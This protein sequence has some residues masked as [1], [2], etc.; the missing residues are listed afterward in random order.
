MTIAELRQEFY[1]S[2]L[3][4]YP[5]EEVGSFLTILSE[6]ILNL[7]RIDLVL[8]SN[9]ELSENQQQE[10]K[11][12]VKRLQKFEPIQYITGET[13]F[14]S[15]PF[16]VNK[17]TLIPRPET[18][19]LV[20][21]ILDIS[22]T[23]NPANLDI[24]DIGTG[25][26]CIAISLAKNLTPA[27]VSALDISSEALKIAHRNA[28][29]NKVAITFE[30][31][32]ILK[33]SKLPKLYDIIVSNPPYVREMEKKA[34]HKNVLEYEPAAA[35]FVS[36]VDPL[37]FYK[38]IAR[39][40]KH[41]LKPGGALFFEINEYLSETL[42]VELKNIGFNAIEIRKDLFGKDRMIKCALHE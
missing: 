19:E 40:A 38:A 36:N 16:K 27:A 7:K 12:A 2:L 34:M 8:R 42:S 39:L 15:L 26:G 20:Q 24:L 22:Q 28:I 9:N 5:S 35:L 32:D 25:S 1:A 10:F 33:V 13:E 30:Q 3:G 31:R 18:E 11:N 29:N 21:W 41:N 14:F 6:K 17:H 4:R 37:V 23:K